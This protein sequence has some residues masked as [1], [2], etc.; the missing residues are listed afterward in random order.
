MSVNPMS[1]YAVVELRMTF[2]IRKGPK[3]VIP[4]GALGADDHAAIT[5]AMAKGIEMHLPEGFVLMGTKLE[6]GD[7]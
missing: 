2:H 1:P 5:A 6:I 4:D 7:L 3:S